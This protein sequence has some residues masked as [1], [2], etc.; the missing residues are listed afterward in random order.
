MIIEAQFIL[1]I[2]DLYVKNPG[3]NT[4][5]HK[6]FVFTGRLSN[7]STIHQVCVP[8]PIVDGRDL[9]AKSQTNQKHIF[10]I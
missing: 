7:I 2:Y 10:V 1:T 9:A 6:L 5:R 3:N 8:R 4:S